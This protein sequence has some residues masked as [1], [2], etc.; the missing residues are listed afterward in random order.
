M[1]NIN[2]HSNVPRSSLSRGSTPNSVPNPINTPQEHLPSISRGHRSS[3]NHSFSPYL[4]E[5]RE[6]RP[7]WI[8]LR[9][10]NRRFLSAARGSDLNGDDL[11]PLS[12]MPS[13][14]LRMQMSNLMVDSLLHV[15]NALSRILNL[16][17]IQRIISIGPRIFGG[18]MN[19]DSL[20]KLP[21]D[22]ELL[23]QI[24]NSS[25]EALLSH[26]D[27]L[28]EGRAGGKDSFQCDSCSICL[29]TFRDIFEKGA[30]EDATTDCEAKPIYVCRLPC[31]HL[32][33]LECLWPWLVESESCPNCRLNLED[34]DSLY[35]KMAEK[36][37]MWWITA[38]HSFRKEKKTNSRGASRQIGRNLPPLEAI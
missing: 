5:G 37:P 12:S 11:F 8:S 33:C 32:F 24:E 29:S 7:A 6:N 30:V 26:S 18:G 25:A 20:Q 3:R 36:A 38:L 22:A 14:E 21:L 35:L 1:G 15:D 13:L 34:I 17:D 31:N 4:S 2:T 28:D 10:N 16:I 27:S 19:F 23:K 9:S